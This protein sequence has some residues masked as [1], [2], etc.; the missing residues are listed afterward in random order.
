MSTVSQ[1]SDPP[2]PGPPGWLLERKRAAARAVARQYTSHPDVRGVYLTGSLVAGLA[3][4]TSDTDLFVITTAFA[5]RWRPEQ[6]D[7]DG[8]RVDVEVRTPA[9]VASLASELGRYNASLDDMRQLYVSQGRLDDAILLT[10]AEDIKPCEVVTSTRT[11]LDAG[12]LRKLTITHWALHA[13]ACLEDVDG[14]R[15]DGDE[16][17]VLLLSRD[18]L[19]YALQA[20]LAGCGELY[21]SLKW[22]WRKLRRS[23]G[24]RFPYET[25]GALLNASLSEVAADQLVARRV[26]CGQALLAAAQLDGWGAPLAQGWSAWLIGGA[27][28][29]RALDWVPLR[30][31]D[32]VLMN[33]SHQE[34]T[35]SPDGL[36]LWGLCDGRSRQAVAR[37]M[38]DDL[39]AS[40]EELE[41][42]ELYLARL[43]DIG[44]LEDD[45]AG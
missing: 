9:Y 30:V 17:T 36:R 35:F 43:L 37:A 32:V 26:R 31:D 44:L 18:F 40:D 4:S 20:F 25:V 42:I 22:T 11:A 10:M 3:S 6:H 33:S 34:L 19:M 27:G 14:V 13:L 23:A 5:D 1:T 21:I 41:S 45:R 39:A 7:Q 28:L 16:E 29:H 2:K 38:R 8:Q 12:A 15:S 24:E